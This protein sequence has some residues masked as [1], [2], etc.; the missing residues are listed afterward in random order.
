A[1]MDTVIDNIARAVRRLSAVGVDRAVITADHGH[2]YAADDRDESLRIDAPGGA[3]VELHRRCW[4]G[5][6]GATPASCIRVAARSLGN[7]SDL[8]FVFPVGIG[9]FRAG[10]DLAFHHGGPSLQELIVPVITV[11]SWKEAVSLSGGAAVAVSDVP[12][13][14]TNRIFSVKLALATHA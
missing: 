1:I 10:G 5:R 13:E 11:R 2:L 8:D 12:D 9:V 6:G 7:D 3:T 4:I 14:V